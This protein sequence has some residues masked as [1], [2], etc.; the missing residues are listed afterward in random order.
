MHVR[1]LKRME[2]VMKLTE[3]VLCDYAKKIFGFAYE[4]TANHYEAEELSSEIMLQLLE[5]VAK[6]KDIEHMSSFIYTVCCYTWSKYLRKNKKHWEHVDIDEVREVAGSTDVEGEATDKLMYAMLRK[7]ISYLSKTHRE[8]VIMHYYE[9]KTTAEIG[10]LL[11]MSDGTVRWYLSNIRDTLKEKFDMSENLDFR[12]VALRVG[13][14]GWAEEPGY[15][16]TLEGDLLVQNIALACYGEPMTITDIS[17]KLNV[18]AAYLE[19]HIE[20]MVYMDYLKQKGKKYQT[21]FFISNL[22]IELAKLN[23]AY[24]YAGPIAEKLFDAVMARKEDFFA[25]DFYGKGRINE[26]FFMWY[27]ILKVAQ[28]ISYEQ[29]Q[30][31]WDDCGLQ[32]PIRKDGSE[33]WIIAE[34][35]FKGNVEDEDLRAYAEYRTCIGYKLNSKEGIG[36]MYQADTY[37]LHDVSGEKFRDNSTPNMIKLLQTAKAIMQSGEDYEMNAFEKLYAAEFIK[38]GYISSDEGKPVLNVPVFTEEQWKALNDIVSEIK[39][40]LGEDFLEEYLNGYSSVVDKCIPKFLDKNVRNYHK[41]AML[42]GFEL[43]AHLI[44]KAIDGDEK[45]QLQIPDEQ[46]AKHAM[47]WLVVKGEH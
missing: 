8:I 26:D 21:N 13:I 35:K 24:S 41:Y 25:I 12:P 27:A 42:G 38:Q 33:Y 17:E 14:D 44:K 31:K 10:R 11:G 29:M 5:C 39:E 36:A 40:S 19:K 28:E 30:K 20:N 15:L 34:K 47:T 6:N 2:I 32:R 3:E 18:A 45:Y 23:Y 43:F 4:K 46:D 9:N 7:Q 22:E 1:L 16:R 37:F